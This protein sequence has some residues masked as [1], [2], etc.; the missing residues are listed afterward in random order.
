MKLIIAGCNYPKTDYVDALEKASE[1]IK[2]FKIDEVI[3]G[4]S[5]NADIA[6]R[7]FAQSFKLPVKHFK[8]KWDNINLP[9]AQVAKSR[10]GTYYNKLAG[11]WRNENLA[12][13]GE[14]LVAV[15]D[16][17]DKI[18]KHLIEQ[19]RLRGKPV[20]VHKLKKKI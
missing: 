20:Y 4:S 15:W 19:V 16:G 10:K 1:K 11:F 8:A 14:A 12:S 9:G 7:R 2:D 17:K 6:G 18:T 13:V 3:I 5:Y